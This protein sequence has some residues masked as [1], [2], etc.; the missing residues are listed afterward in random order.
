MLTRCAIPYIRHHTD[1]VW[2]LHAGDIIERWISPRLGFQKCA[3]VRLSKHRGVGL[4]PLIDCILAMMYQ[5]P[6]A[7]DSLSTAMPLPS[8]HGNYVR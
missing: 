6:D 8:A 5:P 3:V 1:G 7:V 2:D 4:N